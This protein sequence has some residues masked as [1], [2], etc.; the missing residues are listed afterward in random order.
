MRFFSTKNDDLKLLVALGA[1][2]GF[3]GAVLA[4]RG[5][6]KGCP[7]PSISVPK[8]RIFHCGAG[9]LGFPLLLG[10]LLKPLKPFGGSWGL[11]GLAG[12]FLALLEQ[13]AGAG[14]KGFPD[15]QIKK[16]LCG[17]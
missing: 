12:A 3:L 14:T 11:S 16:G 1:F 7:K 6:M 13:N 17:P 15:L 9:I 5:N 10:G 2:G 4:F 8:K